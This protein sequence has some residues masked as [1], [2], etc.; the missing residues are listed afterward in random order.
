MVSRLAKDGYFSAI[1]VVLI[2]VVGVIL[3]EVGL[4]IEELSWLV[5]NPS[6]DFFSSS[7]NLILSIISLVFVVVIFLIQNANQEYS[8]RLSGVIFHN[9]Y[10]LAII[11]V[12]LIASVFNISGSYFDWGSPFTVIGY[13][14]SIATVLLVGSL[15]AFTGY[16]INIANII[17]YITR[18]IEEDI[19]TEQIYRPNYFG[20]P[21][22]DEDYIGQLTSDT[23]LIVST[24]IGAIEKNQRPVVDTCL[25]SLSRIVDKYLDQ[26]SERDVSEGFLQELNDQ[27]KFI[28]SA[29]FEDYSRQK[30]SES[31]VETI[32]DIGV[33]ITKNRELGAQASMWADL[34]KDLFQD[35][36]EF[37]RTAAASLSIQKL[38]EMSV[39]AIEKGDSD[40]VRVFQ[41]KLETIS[42]ICS[43]GNHSYLASLLQSLHGQYQK[44]YAAYIAA[45][46][47]IGFAPEYDVSSLLEVFADS[48]N[49][50]KSN[51]SYM[52]K[53]VLYAG[54][55]GL[56]PFAGRIAQSLS[57]NQDS[58]PRTQRSLHDL[59]SQIVDFLRDIS[60]TNSE[61]NHSD[62]Y[63]GFTQFLFVFETGVPVEDEMKLD[64]ITDLN[65][66]WIELIETTY[67]DAFESSENVD[68]ELN[69]RI[70]DFTAFL[71]YFHRDDPEVLAELIEPYPE[72]YQELSEE[73]SSSGDINERNLKKMYKQL[74]MTGAWINQYHDPESITPELWNVL[75]DD[76][77]EIPESRSRIPRP[78][79]EEYGYP[80]G[81]RTYARDGWWLRPDNLWSY[82]G[83]QDEITESLNGEDGSNYVEFHERLEDS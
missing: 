15:I 38:G 28:G 69:Q 76:F 22:Q 75:V 29:A 13:A 63:K 50:A 51:Y 79:M 30:Y 64:L 45:L 78:L 72:L 49:Q 17:E 36:L 83:F 58:D 41:G 39:T 6:N 25:S 31:V 8:S 26:T 10:F 43:S 20:V 35:S 74:K 48:F 1:A 27:F 34:L 18:N 33:A 73:Y 16:F 68:S 59:L 3:G 54:L 61:E 7:M 82:T 80:T 46:L 2:A 19:A 5:Q 14:F 40:S 9:F 24:C 55:F 23:Q 44:M 56:N 37:D 67:I 4:V 47:D 12:I 57:E 53:Q 21:L 65:E 52:N 60:L 32:G 11:V 62:I 42:T 71:I 66:T 70:S 81:S 77:Y